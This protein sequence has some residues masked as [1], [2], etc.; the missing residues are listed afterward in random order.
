MNL[1]I[2]DPI[3]NNIIRTAA[4][5]AVDVEIVRH[6]YKKVQRGETVNKTTE[7]AIKVVYSR[8]VILLKSL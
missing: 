3:A 1:L 8:L 7:S 4:N 5:M 6:L 2:D